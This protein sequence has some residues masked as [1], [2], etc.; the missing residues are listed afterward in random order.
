MSNPTTQKTQNIDDD[1][2]MA[3]ALLTVITGITAV[4]LLILI[5]DVVYFIHDGSAAGAISGMMRVNL[6]WLMVVIP[7][8][9]YL[10]LKY[11]E[12]LLQKY[13]RA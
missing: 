12:L 10:K 13:G 2:I 4:F 8:I 7:F 1:I 3:R 6:L 5:R 9:T 11:M